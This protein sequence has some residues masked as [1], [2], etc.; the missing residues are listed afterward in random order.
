MSGRRQA[1]GDD[2]EADG[3][4]DRRPP[5]DGGRRQLLARRLMGAVRSGSHRSVGAHGHMDAAFGQALDQAAG[6]FGDLR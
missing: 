5:E 2:A 1:G 3:G 4:D 6:T